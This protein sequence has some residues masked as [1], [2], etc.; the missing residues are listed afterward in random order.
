M[1]TSHVLWNRGMD[2]LLF[3]VI[4]YDTYTSESLQILF[5]MRILNF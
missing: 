1:S 2:R 5:Y 3:H 4:H